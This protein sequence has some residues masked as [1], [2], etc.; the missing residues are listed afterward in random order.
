MKVSL[1]VVVKLLLRFL[2][3]MI[4]GAMGGGPTTAVST[5][6]V[7][8]TAF[9]HCLRCTRFRRSG[10]PALLLALTLLVLPVV[11]RFLTTFSN[12]LATILV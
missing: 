12:S 5:P 8:L 1:R 2:I 6:M 10:L 3:L 4:F 9:D 7:S 11:S